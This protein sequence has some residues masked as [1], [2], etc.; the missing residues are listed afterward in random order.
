MM[1]LKSVIHPINEEKPHYAQ[2]LALV[3]G[4]PNISMGRVKDVTRFGDPHCITSLSVEKNM[5]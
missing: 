3:N 2:C 1:S 4:M 5:P